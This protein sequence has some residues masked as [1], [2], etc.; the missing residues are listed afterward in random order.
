MGNNN[1]QS[2]KIQITTEEVPIRVH[3][4]TPEIEHCYFWLLKRAIAFAQQNGVNKRKFLEEAENNFEE[5]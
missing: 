1:E 2:K 5:A 3:F 4:L